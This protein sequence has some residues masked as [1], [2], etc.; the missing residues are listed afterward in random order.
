MDDQDKSVN[1]RWG[2]RAQPGERGYVANRDYASGEYAAPSNEDDARPIADQE[3]RTAQIRSEID[4]TRAEMSETIEAIEDRLRPR[5]MAS[6]AAESVRDR[7]VGAVKQVASSARERLPYRSTQRLDSG[8][9]VLDRVRE[10]PVPAT[11]AAV[12]IAW[13]AFAGKRSS[14]DG[15]STAIY[16]STV[17]EPYVRETRISTDVGDE[18]ASATSDR[19]ARTMARDAVERSHQV[20]Q[21]TGQRMQDTTARAQH[22]A[23]RMAYENPLMMGAVAAIAGL[24]IGMALP[25]TERENDLMGEARD[26]LVERGRETVRDTAEKVQGVA[27]DVQRIVTNT[28][29]GATRGEGGGSADR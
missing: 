4:H 11:L 16:G 10:N 7:A 6:R 9:G 27:Q 1:E 19:S 20:M 2:Y 14:G 3:R 23:R 18:S 8:S 13:L 28:V 21:R 26:S 29:T 5:N 24:A 22:Q 17:G 12:S 15:Y 25:R